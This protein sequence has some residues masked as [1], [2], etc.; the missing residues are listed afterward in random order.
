MKPLLTCLLLTMLLSCRSENHFTETENQLLSTLHFDPTVLHD[1]R[2]SVNTEM[3]RYET[4]DPGYVLT[5]DGE[6]KTGIVE[7]DGISFK[8]ETEVPENI[9]MHFKDEL[10]ENGYLIF[11]SEMGFE[12]PSTISIIKSN[13]PFDILRLEQTD[14]INYDIENKDVIEK[15]L[16]WDK[17]Y[18]IEIIGADYDWVELVLKKTPENPVDFGQEV[19]AFCPDAVDQGVGE[20]SELVSTI[21]ETRTLYLWWD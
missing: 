15:L 10:R 21:R 4:S 12:S 7:R 5:S 18:G 1:V 19:Y 20:L 2:A 13:D 8:V 3:F 6:Q 16:S 9:I 17:K 11:V 14:G